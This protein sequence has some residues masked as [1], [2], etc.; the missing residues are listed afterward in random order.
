MWSV[1]CEVGEKRDGRAP[2]GH[3]PAPLYGIVAFGAVCAAFL[4]WYLWAKGAWSSGIAEQGFHF[5]LSAKTAL[6]IFR[7]AAGA[8]YWGSGLLLILFALAMAKSSDG[9]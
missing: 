9:T 7:E 6:M 1:V 2:A 4:P 5:S 8:G 3:G